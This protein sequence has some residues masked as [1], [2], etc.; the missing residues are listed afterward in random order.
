MVDTL[1]CE[2]ITD[3]ARFHG[4]RREWDA[5]LEKS[6]STSVFLTWEWLHTWWTHFR[7]G[8]SLRIVIIKDG[9]GRVAGIAPMCVYNKGGALR[10][11]LL[12]FMGIGGVSS[13]YLDVI[14]DQGCE[15]EVGQ[16][17]LDFLNADSGSWDYAVFTDLLDSSVVLSHV[18]DGLRK[19]GY[20]LN[21][22]ISQRCPYLPL[23]STAD[24]FHANLGKEVRSTLKRRTRRLLETGVEPQLVESAD[25]MQTALESLF[26]LHQKRWTLRGLKGNF[27]QDPVRAFHSEAARLFLEKGDLRLYLLRVDG[28][29][30]ASLY[31]FRF[32]G[33]V[34]YYQAGFDPEWASKS[35]GTVLMGY[36]IQQS[37]AEGMTEFD[38]LRGLEP[39]KY[40]WTDK[41][42]T[43]HSLT[44][45]PRGKV[46]GKLSFGLD[47]SI[48]GAKRYAKRLMGR[49]GAK[50]V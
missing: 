13:E 49:V 10:L 9:S 28:S 6:G 41:N 18:E 14:A 16:A 40:R 24:E 33:R 8:S 2:V 30:I 46:K 50:A 22:Q 12:S 45:I 3:A 36:G 5:L 32:K 34:F 29:A 38:F 19:S 48:K 23:P 26:K 17:F 47:E 21:R 35:P 44:A 27:R 1:K 20:L 42:R 25:D 37:I 7:G 4:L 43:T 39:Y 11:K 31:C 15:S